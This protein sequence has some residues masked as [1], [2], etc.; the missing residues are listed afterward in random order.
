MIIITLGN[1]TVLQ[2]CNQLVETLVVKSLSDFE[3]VLVERI[4]RAQTSPFRSTKAHA[5]RRL[6]KFKGFTIASK[7]Q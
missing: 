3:I 4:C 1:A 2:S 7:I 6:T 5:W